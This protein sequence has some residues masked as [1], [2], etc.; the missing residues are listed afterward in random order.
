MQM[1]GD[2]CYPGSGE[3]GENTPFTR[4]CTSETLERVTTPCGWCISPAVQYSLIRGQLLY[5]MTWHFVTDHNIQ[6]IAYN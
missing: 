4:K 2:K 5:G 6:P 3:M 1:R